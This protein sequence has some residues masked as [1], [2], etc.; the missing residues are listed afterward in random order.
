[1][2]DPA[3]SPAVSR[4]RPTWST[5]TFGR[6]PSLSVGLNDINA[7]AGTIRSIV[8]RRADVT[9]SAHFTEIAPVQGQQGQDAIFS[10]Q[11]ST[12]SRAA[13][14]ASAFCAHQ[15]PRPPTRAQPRGCGAHEH[16]RQAANNRR[17]PL[18]C[19]RQLEVAHKASMEDETSSTLCIDVLVTRSLRRAPSRTAA[20]AAAAVMR[21]LRL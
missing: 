3:S 12:P 6:S 1:M 20:A 14:V 13:S 15:P 17:R 9:S 7:A 18:C 2:A 5:S 19:R 10:T 8:A 4:Q 16:A 21:L 11:V